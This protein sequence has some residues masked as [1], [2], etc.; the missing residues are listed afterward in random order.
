MAGNPVVALAA[1]AFVGFLSV[2]PAAA[3]ARYGAAPAYGMRPMPAVPVPAAG[4][5]QCIDNRDV[6]QQM[7]APGPEA[8]Q[9]AC[10]TDHYSF[11]PYA[12]QS[13]GAVPPR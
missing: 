1:A 8:C 9:G 10:A 7:C 12:P 5:C 6:I 4:L 2:Q 11:V 3:Q 13:C